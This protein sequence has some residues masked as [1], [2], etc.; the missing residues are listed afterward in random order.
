[1]INERKNIDNL[2][3]GG[4]KNYKAKAPVHAWDRLNNDLNRKQTHKKLLFVRLLA[5]SVAIL[6][7]FGAGYFYANYNTQA[8]SVAKYELPGNLNTTEQNLIPNQNQDNKQNSEVLDTELTDEIIEDIPTSSD[9]QTSI[10]NSEK[11][12]LASNKTLTVEQT[13]ETSASNLISRNEVLVSPLEMINT[14][15]LSFSYSQASVAIALKPSL[16]SLEFHLPEFS[17]V[18][19][20]YGDYAGKKE[21]IKNRWTMGAQLAPIYSYREISTNYETQG[22]AN[23]Q[24]NANLNN[25]ENALLSY[26]GGVNVDY[27]LNKRWG[28]QSGMYFS[29]IGQVNND[30]L[31]YAYN[32]KD[33]VLLA[34]NTSTGNIN[35]S[36]DKIPDN[37]RIT[38][39]PKDSTGAGSVSIEQNFDFFEVPFLLKYKILNRKFSF[40]LSGGLSP[41]YMVGNSTYLKVDDETYNVGDASNLNS[42]LVNT[43][44]G[45]GLE[46]KAFKK[47]SFS[48]EPT[49]KYSLVSL[50]KDSEFYYHPYSLSFFTGVKF[51]F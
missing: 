5:A 36:F 26:A 31:E 1:M 42:L 4:L 15:N 3:A 16:P 51:S 2:F 10:S 27:A 14:D 11:N 33:G 45:L 7:A 19:Y 23:L 37:I 8:P 49:F 50:N 44:I 38:N 29:R 12:L 46:Y 47:L 40:N 41:A 25:N 39:T 22:Q 48:L 9:H 13:N 32:G 21:S 34:I 24:S 17:G 6:L 28:L 20:T 18:E 43:S 35:I 30:A